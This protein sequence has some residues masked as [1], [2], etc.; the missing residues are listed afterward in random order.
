MTS[1]N[2]VQM[3]EESSTADNSVF[4]CW[5]TNATSLNKDKLDELRI[6]ISQSAPD[7]VFITET[8][9]QNEGSEIDLE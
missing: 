7:I 2:D 4:K 9:W 6:M 1:S 3:A 5:Y 8:W